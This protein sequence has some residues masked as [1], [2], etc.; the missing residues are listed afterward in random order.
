[1][2]LRQQIPEHDV[3]MASFLAYLSEPL[4]SFVVTLFK[5]DVGRAPESL[6]T[7]K[8]MFKEISRKKDRRVGA[9]ST[10]RVTTGVIAS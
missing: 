7:I 2:D 4:E 10:P 1:M 3:T 5:I 6:V 9:R 8:V